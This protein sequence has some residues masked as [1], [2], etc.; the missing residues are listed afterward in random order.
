MTEKNL[1]AE[2]VQALEAGFNTHLNRSFVYSPFRLF[3]N[4]FTK[5]NP[6]SIDNARQIIRE[7]VWEII[8]AIDGFDQSIFL[9]RQNQLTPKGKELLKKCY[10]IGIRVLKQELTVTLAF[11]ALRS[12]ELRQEI[13]R[14]I[15]EQLQDAV[16][17]LIDKKP[18]IDT[19]T[20]TD[21]DNITDTNNTTS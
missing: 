21:T 9:V 13:Y 3:F 17:I 6:K 14:H 12:Y 4:L 5:T 16:V 19:D 2:I 7:D 8:S 1:Q 18:A 11:K 15:L 20:T 10:N